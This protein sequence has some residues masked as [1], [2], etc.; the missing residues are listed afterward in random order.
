M[1]YLEPYLKKRID[2]KLQQLQSLRPLS[3]ASVVKLKHEFRTST[4]F[5]VD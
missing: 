4:S 5:K 2:S 3:S 1:P